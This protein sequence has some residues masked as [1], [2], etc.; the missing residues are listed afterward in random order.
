MVRV[1]CF[2][3]GMSGDVRDEDLFWLSSGHFMVVCN[4]GFAF[5]L[6]KGKKFFENGEWMRC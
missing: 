1:K 4:C 2:G 3:C 6:R 5:P